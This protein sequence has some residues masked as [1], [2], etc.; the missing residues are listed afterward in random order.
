MHSGKPLGRLL[1]TSGLLT[2]QALD[3]VL[4][5]QKADGR[6]L[7]ELLS[8][9][10]LVRPHQL[11]QFLS[12]QLACPWVSL[13]RIEISREAVEVLPRRLALKHHMVP[14]HLRTSKGATALYVAMDDPTDDIALAE[15]AAAATMPVKAMIALTSEIRMHLDRLYGIGATGSTTAPPPMSSPTLPAG[16]TRDEG[17]ALTGP[18]R[19]PKPPPPRSTVPPPDEAA[20]LDVTDVV[21]DVPGSHRSPRATVLVV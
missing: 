1:V 16:A 5:L 12:H 8:E 15:A 9:K 14:V 19:P 3:E 11:A 18:S 20:I 10:G 4:L 21:E 2:Q 17:N 7:G 6:R 13:Q